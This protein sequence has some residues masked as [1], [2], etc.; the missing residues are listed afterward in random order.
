MKRKALLLPQ[1]FFDASGNDVFTRRPFIEEFRS[2]VYFRLLLGYVLDIIAHVVRGCTVASV[3]E[4][5]R[6][7][8]PISIFAMHF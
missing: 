2:S 4:P 8:L 3:L 7:S 5:P 1:N 6:K